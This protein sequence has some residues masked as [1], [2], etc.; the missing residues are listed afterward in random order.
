[1]KINDVKS[2][3][4]KNNEGKVLTTSELTD[5]SLD[6]VQ[7]AKISLEA[8]E[9]IGNEDG[10]QNDSGSEVSDEG[11]RSLGLIVTTPLVGEG[12]V[13][14]NGHKHRLSANSSIEDSELIGEQRY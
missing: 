2:N 6:N 14:T 10:K 8:N 5:L 1:M 4:T 7:R 3:E 13:V 12:K 11:Y 9:S